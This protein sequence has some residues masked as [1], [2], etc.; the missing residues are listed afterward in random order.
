MVTLAGKGLTLTN[1]VEEAWAA[2]VGATAVAFAAWRKEHPRATLDEIE[3][4]FDGSLRRVRAD[5]VSE[6]ATLSERRGL[7][8]PCPECG[9]LMV[10]K[11]KHERSLLGKDGGVLR[12]QRSYQSCVACGVKLFPPG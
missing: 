5:V 2:Q 7:R 4:A 3:D 1:R 10:R 8:Q 6:A 9:A 11:G 12:L